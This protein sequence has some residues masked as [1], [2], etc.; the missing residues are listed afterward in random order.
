M[1]IFIKIF[2]G[3][4]MKKYFIIIVSV[5]LLLFSQL[6]FAGSWQQDG[7][8]Y[9]YIKDNGAYA[10]NSWEW[11]D[12]YNTGSAECYYFNELGYLLV[13]TITPD[14][15]QVNQNGEWVLNGVIQK[16]QVSGSNIIHHKYTPGSSSS[17]STSSTY[18]VNEA[19]SSLRIRCRNL[20]LDIYD[21]YLDDIKYNDYT[22][23]DVSQILRDEYDSVTDEYFVDFDRDLYYIA[24]EFDL[25][26][27]KINKYEREAEEIIHTSRNNLRTKFYDAIEKYKDRFYIG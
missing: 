5:F 9:K 15:Y 16:K 27:S 25:S 23:D 24:R 14:G 10:I 7:F 18:D 26:D 12:T 6:I 11:I 13:N 20:A 21:R 1:D 17:G 19:L 4:I 3:N 8:G 2:G 22:K